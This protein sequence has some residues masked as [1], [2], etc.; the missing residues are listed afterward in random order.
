MG[1]VDVETN[2]AVRTVTLTRPEKRNAINPE[3]MA[4][5]RDVFSVEPPDAERVTVLRAE[6]PVFCSGLQLN[7]AGVEQ[8]EA[9]LIEAMFDAVQKYPL[10]VVA[11]VQGAAIAGGCELALHCDF[12]V[13]ANQA[14]FA[15]PIPQIGVSTTWFL[16]KKIMEAAG[17][18]LAREILLL[19]DALN[20]ERMHELGIIARTAPLDEL[21]AT[22]APLVARLTANAP[23]SMRALKAMLIQQMSFLM[24]IEHGE[25]DKMVDAVWASADALEGVTASMERRTPI[26]IGR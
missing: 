6:G 24:E 2:G 1:L 21:D 8:S 16:T 3:M 9:V 5:L 4:A 15:M 12:I 17:P 23:M 7:I 20:G 26:F 10:P 22:A 25:T 14:L 18:V 11:I 19:G 13:A